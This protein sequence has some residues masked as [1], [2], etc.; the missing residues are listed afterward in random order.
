MP[1]GIVFFSLQIFLPKYRKCFH[2]VFILACDRVLQMWQSKEKL[3]LNENKKVYFIERDLTLIPPGSV[4]SNGSSDICVSSVSF[5]FIKVFRIALLLVWYFISSIWCPGSCAVG[6]GWDLLNLNNIIL[7]LYIIQQRRA[8]MLHCIVKVTII[9]IRNLCF[10]KKYRKSLQL[11]HKRFQ[12]KWTHFEVFFYRT[13]LL[14][15]SFP[16]R[17]CLK[18]FA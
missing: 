7:S 6:C 12:S 10:F 11:Q 18:D 8:V 16:F 2:F 3:S 15:C 13:S 1:K 5:P 17:W 14:L 9:F 4:I